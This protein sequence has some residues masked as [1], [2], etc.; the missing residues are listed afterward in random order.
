MSGKGVAVRGW[1]S[2]S[3]EKLIA[4]RATRPR[5]NA[6]TTTAVRRSNGSVVGKAPNQRRNL[7]IIAAPHLR[8]REQ[9]AGP[10]DGKQ[11]PDRLPRMGTIERL[12][13]P[14]RAA[15]G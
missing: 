11:A 14:I 12:A 2:A 7:V 8:I 15:R 9:S 6:C 4:S 1:D 5:Q 3:Y 13:P 10:L